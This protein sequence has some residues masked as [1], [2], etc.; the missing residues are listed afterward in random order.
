MR[1]N[2]LLLQSSFE[3]GFIV[4]I[5]E[6]ENEAGVGETRQVIGTH[7]AGRWQN[8]DRLRCVRSQSPISV[9]DDSFEDDSEWS[10]G[11]GSFQSLG[12]RGLILN[13]LL[14][15]QGNMSC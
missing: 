15:F 1:V 6:K 5:L 9:L 8:S 4:F 11:R 7:T 2:S 10:W 12:K 3:A 13:P 14:H